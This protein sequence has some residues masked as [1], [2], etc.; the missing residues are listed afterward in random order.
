MLSDWSR[1]VHARIPLAKAAFGCEGHCRYIQVL[2]NPEKG[3]M[4]TLWCNLDLNDAKLSIGIRHN[5]VMLKMCT[6]AGFN[7]IQRFIIINQYVQLRCFCDFFAA[8]KGLL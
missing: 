4:T 3:A 2:V 7:D 5:L 6:R 8:S 1:I